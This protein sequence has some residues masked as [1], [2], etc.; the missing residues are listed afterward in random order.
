MVF[1]L[2]FSCIYFFQHI[3]F[4]YS[5]VYFIVLQYFPC[6]WNF[7]KLYNFLISFLQVLF[8]SIRYWLRSYFRINHFLFLWSNILSKKLSFFI[9]HLCILSWCR[10]LNDFKKWI[11]IFLFNFILN[12]I[13]KLIFPSIRLMINFI[14]YN[15][16]ILI[17]MVGLV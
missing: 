3:F 10:L 11:G 6:L 7:W 14:Y 5:L 15:F 9:N 8:N 4:C 16:L 1:Y 13:I 17:I 12:F 2:N